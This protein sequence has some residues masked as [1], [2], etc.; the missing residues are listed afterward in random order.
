MYL[1]NHLHL[2]QKILKLN[3]YILNLNTTTT[4][5]NIKHTNTKNTQ[6]NHT[7]PTDINN[8]HILQLK[9]LTYLTIKINKTP[10]EPNIKPHKKP[11]HNINN[12][13]QLHEENHVETFINNEL[14]KHINTQLQQQ[15][16]KRHIIH[17]PHNTDTKCTYTLNKTTH[18]GTNQNNHDVTT[19]LYRFCKH[20]KLIRHLLN[21]IKTTKQINRVDNT[22]LINNHLLCTQHDPHHI[23]NQQ[24]KHLIIKINIQQLHTTKNH[25]Q[26]FDHHTNNIHLKL[27]HNQQHPHH[28][29][30]K[31]HQPKTQI[32]HTVTITHLHHPNPSYHTILQNLLK[33]IQ[34]H[35]EEE[36]Q[37][38]HKIINIE[39]T[40]Q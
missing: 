30:I 35:I 3:N 21:I 20:T 26:H 40:Q 10:I 34:I 24:R 39:T 2:H 9:H 16:Y 6:L 18:V 1:L 36:Q 14:N 15:H 37:P 8:H 22:H 29:R 28:L 5:N 25:H 32:L 11:H 23:L 7:Q 31:T 12:K 27:L 38:K 33:K 19:N 13:H 17:N 4:L